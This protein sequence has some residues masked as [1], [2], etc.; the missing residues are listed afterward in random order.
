MIQFDKTKKYDVLLEH[1]LRS[2]GYFD[3]K[4]GWYNHPNDPGGKTIA[5]ITQNNFAWYYKK[6]VKD[7]TAEEMKAM[8]DDHI[9]DYYR[10]D[11]WNRIKLDE[12][13]DWAKAACMFDAGVNMGPKYGIKL[14]QRALKVTDDAILG[15]VTKRA[16]ESMSDE[17]FIDS[18]AGAMRARYSY[19]VS[20]NAKLRVFRKGWS[21]RV[22]KLIKF[23]TTLVDKSSST[24]EASKGRKPDQAEHPLV[25]FFRWLIG[26][27]KK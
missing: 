21:N 9:Y 6:N 15:P 13:K 26:L 27:F 2:E 25:V 23:A 3:G 4:R 12:V 1:V 22:L 11:K 14:A 7:V 8:P 17:D 16:L 10:K 5:G 20:R 24:P 19:L 18:F